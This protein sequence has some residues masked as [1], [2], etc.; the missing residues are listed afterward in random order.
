VDEGAGWIRASSKEASTLRQI[1]A[2]RFL[3]RE[4]DRLREFSRP[5]ERIVYDR[6]SKKT[7]ALEFWEVMQ[8]RIRRYGY[9]NLFFESGSTLVYVS[10]QFER[11]VLGNSEDMKFWHIWTNNVITLLQ[12]LLYTEVDVSRFPPSAPDP[13]DKYYAILPRNWGGIYEKPPQK[14]RS[15]RNSKKSLSETKAVA[16]MRQE[17][18]KF[19]EKALILATASG[20]DLNHKRRHFHGPHVGTHPNFLFKRALFTT[21]QPV[22][23]FLNAEKLGD[24][25]KAGICY[26]IF[27]PDLPLNEALEKYPLAVCVGYDLGMKS[28][29]RDEKLNSENGKKERKERNKPKRICKILHML[30]FKHDYA[31][32][33]YRETGAIIA[34]NTRFK[35]LLPND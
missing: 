8:T 27:G 31:P 33:L 19:G 26:P 11:F 17:L 10:D 15:L 13:K 29:T 12:F 23:I 9:Q 3:E 2:N 20:W 4:L 32:E 16:D 7:L 21:G 18:R 5:G 28:P 25:F 24:P 34:G 22:V 6:I 35:K 1:R 30:G 14:P